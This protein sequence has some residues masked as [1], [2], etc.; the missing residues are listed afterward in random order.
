MCSSD[1]A[2]TLLHVKALKVVSQMICSPGIHDPRWR[3]MGARRGGV[4]G[5]LLVVGAYEVGVETVPTLGRDVAPIAADLALRTL[6]T[7]AIASVLAIPTAVAAVVGTAV[8]ATGGL[9]VGLTVAAR[10]LAVPATTI[11]SGVLATAVAAVV[12]AASV[13][14]LEAASRRSSSRRRGS[15]RPRGAAATAK[16]ARA[17]CYVSGG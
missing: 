7:A 3:D 13:S 2:I 9:A 14:G 4:P 5:A 11:A 8:A 16:N 10:V 15:T 17:R 6:T 1:L 12:W